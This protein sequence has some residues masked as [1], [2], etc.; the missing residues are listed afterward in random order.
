MTPVPKL[1]D[2]LAGATGVGLYLAVG[3][4]YL[5]SGLVVPQSVAYALWAIWVLGL[6]TTIR[7][8]VRSPLRSLFAAPAALA[9][10][11]GFVQLG[12]WLF[13]WTA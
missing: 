6:I 7:A 3:V 2:R 8:V 13:G 10:W 1:T 5:G 9:F 11:I 4:L 12:S